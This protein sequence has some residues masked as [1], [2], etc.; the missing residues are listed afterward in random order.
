MEKN[1]T[2]VQEDSRPLWGDHWPL[3][4]FWDALLL[5]RAKIKTAVL[6]LETPE[7][8]GTVG[9][10]LEDTAAGLKRLIEQA[11][12]ELNDLPSDEEKRARWGD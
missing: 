11:R 2:G 8:A 1:L 10:V 5:V 7:V 6:A 4:S 12:K 9:V 3:G